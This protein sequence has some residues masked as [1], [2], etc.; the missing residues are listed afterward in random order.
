MHPAF[1]SVTNILAAVFVRVCYYSVHVA[2]LFAATPQEKWILFLFPVPQATFLCCV[3][4]LFVV[5]CNVHNWLIKGTAK[6]TY[7]VASIKRFP[8]GNNKYA[9]FNANCS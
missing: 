4:C 5:K 1:I 7:N 9:K 8:R 6:A 3:Q 2:V